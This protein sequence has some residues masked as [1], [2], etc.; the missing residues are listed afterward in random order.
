MLLEI[1]DND[2]KFLQTRKQ[3]INGRKVAQAVKVDPTT[4]GRLNGWMAVDGEWTQEHVW[5]TKISV[6]K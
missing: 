3:E 6:F 4:L 1:T 5:C 2:I